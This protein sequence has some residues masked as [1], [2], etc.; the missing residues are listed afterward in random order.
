MS[1]PCAE[2]G[3]TTNLS[4]Y[5]PFDRC[6]IHVGTAEQTEGAYMRYG[7]DHDPGLLKHLPLWTGYGAC[8]SAG[9]LLEDFYAEETSRGEPTEQ[10]LAAKSL[11]LSC[12]VRLQC[13]TYALEHEQGEDFRSGIFGGLTPNER[14]RILSVAEGAELLTDQAASGLIHEREPLYPYHARRA[15]EVAG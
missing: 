4:S 11:C 8:A 15:M 13:L 12:P 7:P 2:R 1:R 3:C 9:E 6:S 5:N 14:G 10:V